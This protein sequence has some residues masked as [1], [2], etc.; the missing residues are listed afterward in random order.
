M[1]AYHDDGPPCYHTMDII[2]DEQP[3]DAR[4]LG[5]VELGGR[6]VMR[7]KHK[8]MLSIEVKSS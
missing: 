2:L 1:D 7:Q 8:D 3:G 4:L 6:R 5:G